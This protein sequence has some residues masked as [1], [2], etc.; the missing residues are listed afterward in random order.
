MAP[1]DSSEDPHYDF[2]SLLMLLTLVT[3]FNNNGIPM[4][5]ESFTEGYHPIF[6]TSLPTP[7]RAIII[8]AV[9]AILITDGEVV[10]VA[11]CNGPSYAIQPVTKGGIS[12]QDLPPDR[13][14]WIGEDATIAFDGN[15][16]TEIKGFVVVQNGNT[17]VNPTVPQ[18]KQDYYLEPKGL[19]YFDLISNDNW[20][21]LTI[22]AQ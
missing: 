10:A 11:P 4:L 20:N 17:N 8:N 22:T 13:V 14:V 7:S 12:G 6:D 16:P 18:R 2:R 19:S 21:C 15:L 3:S 5:K 9:A 1:K